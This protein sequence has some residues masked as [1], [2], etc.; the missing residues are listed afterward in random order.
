MVTIFSCDH[1]TSMVKPERVIRP[2]CKKTVYESPKE[3]WYSVLSQKIKKLLWMQKGRLRHVCMKLLLKMLG[4]SASLKSCTI[5]GFHAV[6]AW[7]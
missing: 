1:M 2:G 7:V 6:R 4:K 5:A 3:R